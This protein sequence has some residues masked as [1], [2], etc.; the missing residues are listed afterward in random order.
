MCVVCLLDH[1]LLCTFTVLLV[2]CG[3]STACQLCIYLFLCLFM[4]LL[5]ATPIL[6]QSLPFNV[7][8]Y[9]FY[10]FLL[11]LFCASILLY[12]QVSTSTLKSQLQDILV[13]PFLSVLNISRVAVHVTCSLHI[14]SMAVALETW[15]STL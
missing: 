4:C 7:V 3:Q 2:I 14:I 5:I 6:Y 1:N 13:M 10:V 15:T 12:L 11:F 8:L 9:A